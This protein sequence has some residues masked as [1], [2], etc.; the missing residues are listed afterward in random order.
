MIEDIRDLL[1]PEGKFA[2]L[3]DGYE[4]REQQVDMAEAVADALARKDHLLVEAG[5]GVGKTVAYL[6]PAALFATGE[7]RPVVVSTHTINLQGQLVN[8]DIP[9]MQRVMDDH[10][11]SAVL[12]KGRGNFLCLQE[13]DHASA[14]I[15]Y[16]GHK[17]FDRLKEWAK[18]TETGDIGELDFAFQDWHEVCCNPDTCRHQECPYQAERCFYY[19]MRKRAAAADVIVVNHSLFFSDLAIRMMD[20]KAA[21]IPNYG[22]VIFDEA[23]HLE[24]VASDTFGVEFS[25]YR[26]TSLLNRLKKRRDL[27]IPAGEFQMIQ[28]TNDVL[29]DRF[30]EIRKQEFYFDDLYQVA[31]K[32]HVE[33]LANDLVIQLDSLNT[34]L[35]AIDTA[36]DKEF[37]ER[38]QGYRNMVGRM[39]GELRDIFFEVNANYF[40]WAERPSGSRFVKCN[41]H[42]SPVCVAD[43]LRDA[44]W[45][46]ID[47][48]ICTSATLSNSG[49]FCYLKSRLGAPDSNELILG[50]P[51]DFKHQALLYVPD[52]LDQPSEKTEYADAVSD[53]IRE[54]LIA[55]GG[56]AFLLFTSYRMLNE[57]FN[58]LQDRLPFRLLRQGEMSNERLIKEFRED[59]STCLMGVH[60]FWEGVDVKGERLS[61][62]IIDK[63][64]FS[65]PDTPTNKARCAQ[66]EA[67]GGNWFAEYAIPQAQIKLKQGFGRLIRTKT[68][69]GVVAILDSRIHHKYYGREFLRYLPHCPG[70]KKV[71]RIREFLGVEEVVDVEKWGV[72]VPQQEEKPRRAGM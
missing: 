18:E 71:E 64:P 25:N 17:D 67:E 29:F 10:P 48:I 46:S 62:V 26:V 19:K 58:R 59:E 9:L 66:I 41:L 68:D 40:R 72:N 33:K 23:H 57:V 4:H 44:L 55:A 16:Q 30:H 32:Q 49:T 28:S 60:S 52:D 70:T 7:K 42:W 31:D 43:L 2:T 5:T 22:A 8:K 35:G 36:G 27:D 34:Q 39:A 54:I 53:R 69:C 13:L 11:F 61:C 38:I 24:D 56:R 14:L 37:K 1:G 50:S 65:V 45:N 3:C 15:Y 21:I 6:T 63:L 20:P 51:F 47:S 12:M